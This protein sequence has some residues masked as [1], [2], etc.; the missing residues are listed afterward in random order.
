MAFKSSFFQGFHH[1]RGEKDQQPPQLY[2]YGMNTVDSTSGYYTPNPFLKASEQ[3][4]ATKVSSVLGD[5]LDTTGQGIMKGTSGTWKL[6]KKGGQGAGD[7]LKSSFK[8][9]KKQMG[10]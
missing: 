7:M 5:A 6:C 9:C 1:G 3:T 2:S 10:S 4:T 8:A